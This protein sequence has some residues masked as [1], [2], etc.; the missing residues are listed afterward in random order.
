MWMSR[1]DVAARVE[2]EAQVALRE[3]VVE[4][5]DDHLHPEAVAEWEASVL[6][7]QRIA[8]GEIGPRKG[9]EQLLAVVTDPV[10]RGHLHDLL[11]T[12]DKPGL[13]EW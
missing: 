6:C 13:V 8:A 1:Y 5:E 4:T 12:M 9:V 7:W 3:L 10:A 2:S 11:Y